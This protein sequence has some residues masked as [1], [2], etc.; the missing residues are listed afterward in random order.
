MQQIVTYLQSDMCWSQ[1]SY[2][3]ETKELKEKVTQNP[4]DQPKVEFN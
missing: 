2:P 1:A 3:R 4:N